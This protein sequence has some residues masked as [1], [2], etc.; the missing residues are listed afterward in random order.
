MEGLFTCS[1]HSITPF[2]RSQ[3]TSSPATGYSIPFSRCFLFLLST[4]E[5]ILIAL[6][7]T[8]LTFCGPPMCP[9]YRLT[10]VHKR[11]Q[12]RQTMNTLRTLRIIL[13]YT[14]AHV[15]VNYHFPFCIIS[16]NRKLKRVFFIAALS[17]NSEQQTVD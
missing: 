13:F 7:S 16:N 17:R 2:T 15:F 3:L 11:A 10:Y 14:K 6:S 8:F 1:P 12:T 9:P 5:D 4:Q